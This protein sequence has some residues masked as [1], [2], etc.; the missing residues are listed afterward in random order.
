[1]NRT[2]TLAA[3]TIAAT[4][5]LVVRPAYAAPALSVTDAI[6]DAASVQIAAGASFTVNVALNADVPF[7]GL[8][9]VLTASES[10]RFTI[11]GRTTA[12]AN[13]LEDEQTDNATLAAAPLSPSS[14]DLGYTNTP[15]NVNELADTYALASYTITAS[16]QLAPGTYTLRTTDALLFNFPGDE[17]TIAPSAVYTVTVVPEPTA[18]AAAAAAVVSLALLRRR[19]EF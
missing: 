13:P 18:I 7:N 15:A 2:I 1:M 14:L 4:A 6:G 17:F 12:I 16:A 3:V 19:R 11:T 9:F 10:D 5:L 8:S